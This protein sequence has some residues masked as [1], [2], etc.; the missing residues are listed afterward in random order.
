MRKTLILTGWGWKEYP[1]AAALVLKALGGDTDVAGMSR[2]RLPEFLESYSENHKRII[3]IGVSLSGDEV[4]LATALAALK[5]RNIEV[6]W[7]S[8]IDFS[9]SQKEKLAPLLKA[10]VFETSALLEAVGL[11]FGVEILT[12]IKKVKTSL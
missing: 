9:S 4:R 10:K 6:V 12:F 1:V 3:I 8:A 7:I 5:K 2:R 11:A